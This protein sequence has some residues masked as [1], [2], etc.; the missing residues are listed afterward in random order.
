MYIHA[1]IQTRIQMH[2]Y[3]NIVNLLSLINEVT[4]KNKNIDNQQDEV[5]IVRILMKGLE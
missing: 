3:R 5:I 1:V 2:I 4:A